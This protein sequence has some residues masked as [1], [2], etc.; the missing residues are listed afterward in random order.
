MTACSTGFNLF[1][2]LFGRDCDFF[3]WLI[4]LSS[5]LLVQACQFFDCFTHLFGFQQQLIGQRPLLFELF[6]QGFDLLP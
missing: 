5:Q 1:I 4:A 6:I 3:Y 2:C